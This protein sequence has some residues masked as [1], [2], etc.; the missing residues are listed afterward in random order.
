[1]AAIHISNERGAELAEI[2]PEIADDYRCG[3][4]HQQIFQKYS[5]PG[6]DYL[7]VLDDLTESVGI[8]TVRHALHIL[9]EGTELALIRKARAIMTGE[10]FG[11]LSCELGL[12]IHG[13]TK[14]ELRAAASAG[15]Q[16]ATELGVGIHAIGR[17]GKREAQKRSTEVQRQNG[18][19][20]YDQSPEAYAA[21]VENGKRNGRKGGLSAK[22]KGVGIHA[23]TR[24]EL[25]EAGRKGIIGASKGGKIGGA[26]VR[27]EGLGIFAMSK[28]EKSE[29]GRASIRKS[30]ETQG[31]VMWD[32]GRVDPETGLT[33]PELLIYLS[34][35]DEYRNSA[36]DRGRTGTINAVRIAERLN[37]VFHDGGQ[38]RTHRAVSAYVFRLQRNAEAMEGIRA[39][40]CELL[41]TLNR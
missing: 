21:R 25:R 8:S 31:K 14:E 5:A 36:H 24:E 26:K 32:H 22:K 40:I 2:K 39:R 35:L 9:L 20:F 3:M 18:T 29:V 7:P 15:G 34:R 38:V 1:M 41:A 11:P 27:D 33:E 23:M 19:G 30:L 12:G 10:K 6:P 13:Q 28:E 16:K 17:E 4:T 37:E